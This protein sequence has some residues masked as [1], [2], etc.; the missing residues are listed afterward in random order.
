MS[1]KWDSILTPEEKGL[2]AGI[3]ISKDLTTC[4]PEQV[5]A[6]AQMIVK[7]IEEDK[8]KSPDQ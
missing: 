3:Y 5:K 4:S 7:T 1:A 8:Q 6:I 2:L